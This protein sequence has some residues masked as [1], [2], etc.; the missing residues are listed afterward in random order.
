MG[1]PREALAFER[2]VV[3]FFGIVS[4][5]GWALFVLCYG[6]GG[7]F[8]YRGVLG[9]DPSRWIAWIAAPAMLLLSVG[10]VGLV[11]V[12]YASLLGGLVMLLWLLPRHARRLHRGDLGWMAVTVS[13]AVVAIG[14]W[15][16]FVQ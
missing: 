8:L 9:A 4:L 3:R 11:P 14:G 1:E 7:L 5:I 12:A 16:E 13:F 15:F 2:T 6:V 10:S